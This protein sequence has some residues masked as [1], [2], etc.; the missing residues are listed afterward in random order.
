MKIGI[1]AYK[2]QNF[3]VEIGSGSYEELL[4]VTNLGEGMEGYKYD[5]AIRGDRVRERRLAKRMT[6]LLLGVRAALGCSAHYLVGIRDDP[7]PTV[8]M[9]PIKLALLS[10]FDR[11][12]ERG[13]AVSIQTLKEAADTFE[14]LRRERREKQ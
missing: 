4:S 12:D 6:Q 10:H 2:L 7:G 3:V 9:N 14:A 5:G 8:V 11:L 1:S 13:K